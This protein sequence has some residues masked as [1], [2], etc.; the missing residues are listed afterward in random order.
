M[1]TKLYPVF[2][3]IRH[4]CLCLASSF[5]YSLQNCGSAFVNRQTG[6]PTDCL[7]TKNLPLPCRAYLFMPS[8]ALLQ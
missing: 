1:C 8:F 6:T 2:L 7:F 5:G 3:A 4:D